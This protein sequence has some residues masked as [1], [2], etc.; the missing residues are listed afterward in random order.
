MKDS[1]PMQAD[2]GGWV[3]LDWAMLLTAGWGGLDEAQLMRDMRRVHVTPQSSSLGVSG[4]ATAGL[5]D[6]FFFLI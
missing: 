4:S 6:T 5:A 1:D 3:K 2:K